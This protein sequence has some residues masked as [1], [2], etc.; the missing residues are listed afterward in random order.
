MVWNEALVG[1][2]LAKMVTP[3]SINYR[4]IDGLIIC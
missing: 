1:K 2:G 3:V 4:G